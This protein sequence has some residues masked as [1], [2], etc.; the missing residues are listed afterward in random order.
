MIYLCTNSG[1][2]GLDGLVLSHFYI[3][4]GEYFC[5][6]ENKKM[7]SLSQWKIESNHGISFI[8]ID[9]VDMNMVL[10]LIYNYVQI[11]RHRIID[12][13]DSVVF[14]IVLNNI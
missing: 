12:D 11:D 4:D 8:D 13:L 14:K 5:L 1:N 10:P 3:H 7:K 2:N 6:Q 9:V